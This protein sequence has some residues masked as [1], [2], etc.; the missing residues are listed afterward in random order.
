MS[1]GQACSETNCLTSS[2]PEHTPPTAV[3]LPPPTS[4]LP[5]CQLPSVVPFAHL[6]TA[7]LLPDRPYTMS[8]LPV[9]THQAATF[10]QL[11][12][13]HLFSEAFQLERPPTT[14]SRQQHTGYP[15]TVLPRVSG[16]GCSWLWTPR[17]LAWGSKRQEHQSPSWTESPMLY[18][19]RTSTSLSEPLWVKV[20]PE[21]PS[22][23]AIWALRTTEPWIPA[24]GLRQFHS[25]WVWGNTCLLQSIAK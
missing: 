16:R 2:P 21:P 8:S 5:A 24:G 19:V 4:C 12:K 10:K 7:G 1:P 3:P 23:G 20:H 15:K 18:L 17:G 22:P 6:T 11:R 14:H 9:N 25:L 13:P